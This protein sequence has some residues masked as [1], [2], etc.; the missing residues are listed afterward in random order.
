LRE[1]QQPV[2]NYVKIKKSEN[3]WQFTGRITEL[4][5]KAVGMI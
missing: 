3:K 5:M 1:G 4:R 2:H